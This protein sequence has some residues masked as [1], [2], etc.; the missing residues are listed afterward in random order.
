M[1]PPLSNGMASQPPMTNGHN[2]PQLPIK[3]IPQ[4]QMQNMQGIPGQHRQSAPNPT[5]DIRL[6][7]QAQQISEQQ[8]QAVQMQQQGRQHPGQNS[9]IHNSP[10]N[11]RANMSNANQQSSLLQNQALMAAFNS[12]NS[13]GSTPPAN[14]NYVLANSGSSGSP[15]M[16]LPQVNGQNQNQNHPNGS[17]HSG[18]LSH[19][20]KLEAQA[21][22]QFPNASPD[23]IRKLVTDNLQ[24]MASRQQVSQAAMHAA[25]GGAHPAP[26]PSH[27]PVGHPGPSLVGLQPGMQNSPQQ[28]A[29][30]LRAQQQ[31][32]AAN[33]AANLSANNGT[34][35]SNSNGTPAQGNANGN[36]NG[37][38]N[39]TGGIV[40]NG[41]VAG[42]QQGR[43][44]SVSSGQ[45]K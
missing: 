14:N 42:S 13:N 24:A 7:M 8:R 30:M 9:Q 19:V 43:S 12:N 2:M 10:P 33:A 39:G 4:A 18:G 6:V 22:A 3:G 11:M 5:P 25:A 16:N 17:N 28:Y 35:N 38:I 45:G 21:R 27:V 31:Q 37:N 44:A 23:H 34:S 26:S 29:Q 20:V 1:Q 32:Q 41:G 36:V 40:A 15:R